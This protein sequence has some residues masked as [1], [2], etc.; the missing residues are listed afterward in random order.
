MRYLKVFEN[1]SEPYTLDF[2]DQGFDLEE[3]GQKIKGRYQGKV[4]I[5]DLNTWYAELVDRL[6]DEWEVTQSKHSFNS[7]SGRA[8]FEIE[9][10]D[11]ESDGYFTVLKDGVEV[12]L[13]PISFMNIYNSRDSFNITLRCKLENGTKTSFM[14]SYY[15]SN[16]WNQQNRFSFDADRPS[17]VQFQLGSK[18]RGI[19]FNKSELDNFINLISKI[20]KWDLGVVVSQ[21]YLGYL[22]EIFTGEGLR[23]NTSL[24]EIM[25][26]KGIFK[27]NTPIGSGY[28]VNK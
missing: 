8:S 3:T 19:D 16:S 17:V 11:K 7:A 13:Y 12:K 21:H 18:L 4:V 15:D 5:S 27:T 26:K 14:I 1:W 6:N 10:M 25:D 28:I 20:S 9:I 2:Q 24:T 23:L 22:N